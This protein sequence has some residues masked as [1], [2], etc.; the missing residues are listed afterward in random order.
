MKVKIKSTNSNRTYENIIKFTNDLRKSY[1]EIQQDQ[2]GM[3]VNTRIDKIDI[4]K[5]EVEEE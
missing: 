2:N 5:I 3:T 4:I 1:I